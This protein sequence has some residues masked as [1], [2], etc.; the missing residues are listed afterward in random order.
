MSRKRYEYNVYSQ[1]IRRFPENYWVCSEKDGKLVF[2]S[3]EGKIRW[4]DKAIAFFLFYTNLIK[5]N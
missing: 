3:W 5:V 1:T 2:D 4:Y